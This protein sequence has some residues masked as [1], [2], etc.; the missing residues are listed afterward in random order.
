VSS[1]LCL[2]A[3]TDILCRRFWAR[4]LELRTNLE[5]LA[6]RV[7]DLEDALR[8][9]HALN[10]SERH[11]LLEDE[12][13]KVKDPYLQDVQYSDSGSDSP[14]TS[15]TPSLASSSVSPERVIKGASLRV[16]VR[17]PAATVRVSVLRFA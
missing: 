6:Q 9:A 8:A 10:A 15:E 2:L 3:I 5:S 1:A 13:L 14:P 11:P 16:H 4:T 12:L 7:R 17:F